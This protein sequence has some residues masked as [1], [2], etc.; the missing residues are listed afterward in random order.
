MKKK[1]RK[2][3]F[4]NS[5]P[6]IQFCLI[7][8]GDIIRHA[9][10]LLSIVNSHIFYKITDFPPIKNVSLLLKFQLFLFCYFSCKYNAH[11][12]IISMT[13]PLPIASD[14][15]IN[16]LCPCKMYTNIYLG[17]ESRDRS[18]C[19]LYVQCTVYIYI[20]VE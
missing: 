2:I 3:N 16:N 18:A 20:Y 10:T 13:M 7:Y 6:C 17:Y 4:S 19:T 8:L 5:A 1:F 12:I 14:F 11:K 15:R 9:P